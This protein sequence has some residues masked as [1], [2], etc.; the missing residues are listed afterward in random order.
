MMPA[1]RMAIG[2]LQLDDRETADL[3]AS[4]SAARAT[5]VDAKA[6]AVVL[7]DRQY[8]PAPDEARHFGHVLREVPRLRS[9]STDRSSIPISL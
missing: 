1:S 2:L 6:V 4:G 8:R 3:R 7:D 9:R 5:G